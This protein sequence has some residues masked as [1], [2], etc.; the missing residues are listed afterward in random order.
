M[1]E[2]R[3]LNSLNL[4]NQ[5]VLMR[6]DFNVP[7]ESGKVTD[8]FRIRSALPSILA[9]LK[10]GASVVL[11]SHLGR[12]EGRPVKVLSLIEV[13]EVLCD[14]IEKPVKFSND[15]VS[16]ESLDVSGSLAPG[17]VHLLENL[18]FHRGETANDPVFSAQLAL[19]GTVYINDAFGTA[20]RAHASN[21]G[22]VA[23]F[24]EKGMGLLMERE[25]HFLKGSLENP[26]RPLTMVVGGAKI[27]TK[28]ALL[29][30]FVRDADAILVGGG[31]AF[32]FLKS[33][34]LPVG[35]SLIDDAAL[36][37][38]GRILETAR[39][40]KVPFHLP[41]DAVVTGD[42]TR[43]HPEGE[44]DIHRIEAHLLGADIGTKTVR[45]FQ[46]VIESSKTVIWNGPMG[47][48]ERP[49][50]RMGTT[51]VGTAVARVAEA[52][53]TAVVGGG[54]TALAVRKLGLEAKMTH[55]STGGGACLELLT[56]R[57]LPAFEALQVR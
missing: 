46:Q 4:K 53:G 28:L 24:Q 11:M 37:A 52:G 22:V 18:R 6:V 2:V 17:E 44:R 48:F 25:F 33:R 50:F 39:E 9:C 57:S 36:K 20:H 10:E 32:T 21:V 7:V 35:R 56:G 34:G 3:T 29:G 14:L 13:G 43:G 26:D 51:A 12:P 41:L 15:C 45:L 38:A 16:G 1:K 5:R 42:A 55:I 30:R 54:D 40:R 19:H 47:I 27:G 8:D 49:D 31:M 23:H